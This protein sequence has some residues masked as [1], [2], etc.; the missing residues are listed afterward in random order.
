MVK[1][2]KC[3]TDDNKKDYCVEIW[4]KTIGYPDRLIYFSDF[5]GNFEDWQKFCID[6]TL[7]KK[8]SDE[9]KKMFLTFRR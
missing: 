2:Y 9:L 3:F 5:D 1:F 4:G 8:D 7:N 6:E